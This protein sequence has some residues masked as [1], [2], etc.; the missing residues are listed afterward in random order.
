MKNL[1]FALVGVVLAAVGLSG[2]AAALPASEGVSVR[3]YAPVTRKAKAYKS[4]S[5]AQARVK[6]GKRYVAK[7]GKRYAA[8]SGKRKVAYKSKT[9]VAG[10]AFT[11]YTGGGSAPRGCL[12]PAARSLLNRIESRFGSVEIVSTCRPGAV[13][14]GTNK[15][16]RHRSG[17]AIDF[18]AGSR[19]GAIVSWLIANHHSGGTMTYR[20]MNHIHVD[21]GPRFV[22]LGAG[23]RA[24]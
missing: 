3:E 21:I 1:C 8:R 12:T 5:K 6:T 11:R 7:T 16:S 15:P 18:S 4:Q 19:K 14:A 2:Q 23:S 10:R 22:K 9:R 24:G 20:G 17:N 13:I